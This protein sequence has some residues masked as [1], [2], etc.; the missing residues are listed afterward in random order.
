M[1]RPDGAYKVEVPA[2]SCIFNEELE[3]GFTV[4]YWDNDC[5]LRYLFF[6]FLVCARVKKNLHRG[7]K[8]LVLFVVKMTIYLSGS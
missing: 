6:D 3:L 1:L 5:A 8:P 2:T 7:Q 4:Q